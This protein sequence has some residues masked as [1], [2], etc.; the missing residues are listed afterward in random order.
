MTVLEKMEEFRFLLLLIVLYGRPDTMDRPIS[1]IDELRVAYKAR[2]PSKGKRVIEYLVIN[3]FYYSVTKTVTGENRPKSIK[4][5]TTLT[6][7][8]L[9]IS[10]QVSLNSDL[11]SCTL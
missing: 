4:P 5:T 9:I 2:Y 3:S 7:T 6:N 1:G 11:Y 10:S 8:G